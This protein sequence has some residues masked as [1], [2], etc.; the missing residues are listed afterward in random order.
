MQTA[1]FLL[2]HAGT[3]G[4]AAESEGLLPDLAAHVDTL[5][6]GRASLAAAAGHVGGLTL[7]GTPSLELERFTDH[8]S[9]SSDF[10]QD[11]QKVNPTKRKRA[12]ENKK[13]KKV[14]NIYENEF[15]EN[16]SSEEEKGSDQE[17][18]SICVKPFIGESQM[19]ERTFAGFLSY[20]WLRL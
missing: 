6:A 9:D 5:P 2:T 16:S 17:T 14:R 12:Q 11:L 20:Q 18:S 1:N 8:S 13:I 19:P 10:I 4:V 3:A 7:A 15:I